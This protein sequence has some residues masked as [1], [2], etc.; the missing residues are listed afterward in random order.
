MDDAAQDGSYTMSCI[1]AGAHGQTLGDGSSDNTPGLPT[2][3]SHRPPPRGV[4]LASPEP[5]SFERG[6]WALPPLQRFFPRCFNGA[7]LFRARRGLTTPLAPRSSSRFNGAA[8]FRARRE[9]SSQE[10]RHRLLR[11]NG[12]ALF[13][14]RRGRGMLHAGRTA[15][16]CFNGAALFRARRGLA[17]HL[18]TACARAASTGPRSFERGEFSDSWIILDSCGSLQRGRALSSAES[19]VYPAGLSEILSLQ[20]GRALS[21]AES[22]PSLPLPAQGCNR[23]IATG[24]RGR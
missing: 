19:G 21:S 2:R 24:G 15:P 1:I 16:S 6:E 23:G 17:L 5:R 9:R 4:H 7:A 13:R 20:R 12:A 18:L 3:S 22:D 14:A 10:N 11:F 8:L